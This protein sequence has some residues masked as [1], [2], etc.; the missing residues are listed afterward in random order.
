MLPSFS[1]SL[2]LLSATSQLANAVGVYLV[3]TSA[4]ASSAVSPDDALT[5][6]SRHFGLEAFQPLRDSSNG[7]EHFVGKGLKSSLLLTMDSADV[8]G[9]RPLV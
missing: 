8:D 2:L 4:L 6:L 9:M 3:P 7:E 5:T 1:L